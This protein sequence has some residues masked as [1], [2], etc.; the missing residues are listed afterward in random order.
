MSRAHAQGLETEQVSVD[1][2][3]ASAKRLR[4]AGKTV[5]NQSILLEVMERQALVEGKK[6]RKQR[7]KE[8][9]RYKQVQATPV[10]EAVEPVESDVEQATQTESEFADIEVWDLDEL[11]VPLQLPQVT[12]AS[13]LRNFGS[14]LK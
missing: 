7:Q 14:P 1:E 11:R 9:Q 4:E 13:T 5:S 2:A 10:V 8:E 6:S 12:F 3:K